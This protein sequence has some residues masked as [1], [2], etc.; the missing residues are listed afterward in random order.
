MPLSA[1]LH[2]WEWPWQPWRRVHVDY[3]GPLE[4]HIILV[5]VDAQSKFID[6][7]V[8]STATTSITLTKLRQT[9]AI[10]GLPTTIVSDLCF[11][12]EEIQRFC[13]TNGVKHVTVLS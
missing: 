13:K 11:T 2:P 1:P 7:H 8:V 6:A 9:F 3:A 12:S 10:L 5:I 4:G